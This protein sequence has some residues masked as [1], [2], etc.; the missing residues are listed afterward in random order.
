MDTSAYSLESLSRYLSEASRRSATETPDLQGA[1]PPFAARA[2]PTPGPEHVRPLALDTAWQSAQ[3]A[4]C[5]GRVLTGAVTGWNRG[6]L[7]VRWHELQ[8]F[9]PA[10]QLK[11][12]P[13]FDDPQQREGSLARRVG[14][15]LSLKVIELDR[16]RNRLVFSERATLWGPKDGDAVLAQAVPGEVRSGRVSNVCDFGVFVDLGGVDGL[17]HLSEL[18]WGRVAHPR[19]VLSIGERVD[20][21]VISVDKEA[22]RIALSLKRLRPDPWSVVD[23]KFHTGDVLTATITNMVAFGAFAQIEEGLEG[24]IHISEMSE[25]K[26]SHPSEVVQPGDRVQVRVLRIDSANHRLGLSMRLAHEGQASHGAGPRGIPEEDF[27]DDAQAGHPTEA[28]PNPRPPLM[29]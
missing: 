18:S 3:E 22:R 15:E 2:E 26:I 25:I 14:E 16:S 12:V 4:L 13:L 8:G 11:E 7:L 24:L 19:D 10:S 23:Q 17:I 1:A 28:P 21:Y 6:G 9:V 29:Y 20:A 5:D 27:E